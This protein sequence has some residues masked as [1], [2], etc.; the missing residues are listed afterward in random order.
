M[1]IKMHGAF[2]VP[3]IQFKFSKHANYNWPEVDKM[4]RKPETWHIPLNTS[5]PNIKDDDPIVDPK[6]RDRL[7]RDLTADM[8]EVLKDLSILPVFELRDFW[9]NIYHDG[10]GQEPHDH[11]SDC[12]NKSPF[13]SVIYYAKNASPTVFIRPDSLGY[14]TQE[15]PLWMQSKINGCFAPSHIPDVADG[16]VIMFPPYIKHMVQHAEPKMRMTFATNLILMEHQEMVGNL[17]KGF[18]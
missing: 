5:F 14:R 8:I 10:Q 1:E 3:F 13:W 17:K 2:S 11:L 16:D 4:E 6:T 9:Y 7:K 18:G 12:M 15:F